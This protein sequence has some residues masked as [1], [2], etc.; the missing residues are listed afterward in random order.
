M[1]RGIICLES[2]WV[3]TKKKSRLQLNSEPLLQFLKESYDI[4][5]IYRRIATQ[6]ELEYYLRQF[7]KNEYAK[8]EIIYFS[9]HGETHGIQLEGEK[10]SLSLNDLLSIKEGIFN[11]R[12]IHFSSCRT[13]LGSQKAIDNFKE[14]SGAKSVSGYTKTVDSVLSAIHDIAFFRECQERN[15]IPSIFR[16]LERRYEGIQKELGFRTHSY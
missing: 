13:L 10:E 2:E 6:A 16:Q 7:S 5:Y 8:Y 12:I 11:N 1:K 14:E 9:F 3:V 4:P 15:Q